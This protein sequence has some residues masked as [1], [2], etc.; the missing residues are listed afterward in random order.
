MRRARSFSL[1]V[2]YMVLLDAVV[3]GRGEIYFLKRYSAIS[4]VAIYSI[5]F[6]LMNK[7]WDAARTITSNFGPMAANAIG[8]SDPESIGRLLRHTVRYS[9]AFLLPTCILAVG[10]IKPIVLALFG[11]QYVTVVP[12]MLILLLAPLLAI[13]SE[14][15]YAVIYAFERQKFVA[16]VL[17]PTSFLNLPIAWVLVPRYGALGAAYANMV[18]QFANRAFELWYAARIAD[19]KVSVLS[20]ARIWIFAACAATP[21]AVSCLH[22]DNM[23]TT[24]LLA[25][26]GAIG[27]FLLLLKLKEFTR[28]EVYT[29]INLIRA[30]ILKQRLLFK[31]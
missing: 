22:S 27:F 19:A 11:K 31:A 4:E 17:T 25:T 1:T 21:A 12:V 10:L 18:A 6:A 2:W 30:S 20:E 9:N 3:W 8:R 29:V 15:A 5:A 7:M 24:F 14:A 23:I 13:I 26:G 28:E 16:I